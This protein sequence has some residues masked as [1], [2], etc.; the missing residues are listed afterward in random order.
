MGVP[1]IGIYVNEL[2]TYYYG[3]KTL[4]RIGT[5]GSIHMKA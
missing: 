4:M 3:C 5:A 2:I 1:S